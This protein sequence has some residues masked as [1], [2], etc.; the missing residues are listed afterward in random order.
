MFQNRYS[1]ENAVTDAAKAAYLATCIEKGVVHLNKYS[2]DPSEIAN[3]G[4]PSTVTSR[5]NKLIRTSPEAL[6]YWI[7]IGNLL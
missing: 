4:L 6:F 2:G 3:L 5:L 7:Q 1:I